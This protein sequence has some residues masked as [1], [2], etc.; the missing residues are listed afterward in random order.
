[1]LWNRTRVLDCCLLDIYLFS[2]YSSFS[3]SYFSDKEVNNL[4]DEDFNVL[5]ILFKGN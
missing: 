2:F 5:Y 4:I 1:M 3:F